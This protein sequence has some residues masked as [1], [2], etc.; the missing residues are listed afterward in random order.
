[1]SILNLQPDKTMSSREIAELT[2]K[3]HPHV[4]R[5]IRAIIKK[6][7]EAGEDASGFVETSVKDKQNQPRS[8]FGLTYSASMILVSGY[9]AVLRSKIVNRW[10]ALEN[11]A[12]ELTYE[13]TMLKALTM[14]DQKVKT[15]V[16]ENSTLN[17]K[18]TV[19]KPK[20]A[21]ADA[22]LGSNNPICIRDWVKT[23]QTEEGLKWGERKVWKWF[24][25]KNLIFRQNGKPRPYAG[26]PMDYF[27]LE[28][29]VIA[30]SKGNKEQFSFKITGIGQI[31]LGAKLMEVS[32]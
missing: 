8:I 29:I 10:Q 18:I 28:P 16:L 25:E 19:D 24:E 4:M 2:D 13:E 5:D 1:M 31:E 32:E 30:T 23:L 21:Y 11:A 17:N 15:L 6:L 22:V 27:T 7:S 12:P 26:K 3:Q 14:A 9:N 20:V